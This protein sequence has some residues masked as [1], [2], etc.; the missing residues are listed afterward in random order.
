MSARRTATRSRRSR[1]GASASRRLLR[2][3]KRN[4]FAELAPR[5]KETHPVDDLMESDR[6]LNRI[7][8]RARRL[9]D[10]LQARSTPHILLDFEAER[11]HLDAARVEVAFNLGFESGLINGRAEGLRGAVRRSLDHR[12]RVLVG[13]VQAALEVNRVPAHRTQLLLQELA[14]SLAAGDPGPVRLGR[15]R[16]PAG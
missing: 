15:R 16:R 1:A 12:E 3:P 10:R 4:Y 13:D 6:D 7:A 5:A 14:W 2:W 9:L 8:R 11:N